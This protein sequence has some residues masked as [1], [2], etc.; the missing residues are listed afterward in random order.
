[1]LTVIFSGEYNLYPSR[2]LAGFITQTPI[3][4]GLWIGVRDVYALAG[5]YSVGLIGVPI[6]LWVFALAR[7]ICTSFFGLFVLAFCWIYLISGFF[8]VGEYSVAY[9]LAAAAYA[10]LV[11]ARIGKVDTLVLLLIAILSARAYGLT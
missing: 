11:S 7:T 10:I 8:S 3:L 2:E 6:L 5:L 9:A 4:L 1:M